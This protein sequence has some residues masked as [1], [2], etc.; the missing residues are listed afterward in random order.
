MKKTALVIL[1]LILLFSLLAC[2]TDN[3]QQNDQ[4]SEQNQEFPDSQGQPSIPGE[5]IE[6]DSAENSET[7]TQTPD[8]KVSEGLE[9][10][11]SE[12]GTYYKVEGIG[13]CTDSNV[14]IP[15]RYMNLP[16]TTISEGAFAYQKD[17]ASITIPESITKI[18]SSVFYQ[19]LNLTSITVNKGNANYTSIGGNLYSKDGKYLIQYA[20]GKSETLFAIPEGVISISGY[21]FRDCDN[22][23]EIII[24]NSLTK[25]DYNAFVQCDNIARI[26]YVGTSRE[27]FNINI[28]TYGN[29]ILKSAKRY[30]YFEDIPPRLNYYWHYENGI[31][32]VW[33]ECKDYPYSIGLY[34]DKNPDGESYCVTGVGDCSEI[35]IIIPNEYEGLPVTKIA[36]SVF[37]NQYTIKS[38]TVPESVTSIG[39]DVFRNCHALENVYLPKGLSAIGTYAFSYCHSLLSI[40][41]DEDNEYYCSIDGNLYSKDRNTLIKYASGKKESDF[42]VPNT[43]TSISTH[44]FNSCM[45]LVNVTIPDC[46]TTIENGAFSNCKKLTTV[47]LPNDINAIGHNTF[48]NCPALT[49]VVI[50]YSVSSIG[51]SAFDNCSELSNVYYVGTAEDWA[52]ISID[53]TNSYL[54]NATRYYYSDSE[55]TEEGNFWHYDEN[56]EVVVW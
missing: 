17:I 31:A 29:D 8:I 46:V 51:D 18:E 44:A 11:L 15:S 40:T 50:P 54:T 24:P 52:N 37:E 42:V 12:D 16:V 9:F 19:C 1:S 35:R 13:D 20:I 43:V 23:T 14:V 4:S 25:I 32:T 47:I 48:Y 30:Y 26:F 53:S 36:D 45:Y 56:G 34:Y 27:W 7:N 38:V 33:N 28:I 39:N 55:P 21:A 2:K 5:D 6:Q 3:S 10:S 22:L 49:N 41:V